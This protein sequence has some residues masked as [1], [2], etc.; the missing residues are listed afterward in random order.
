MKLT[1]THTHLFMEHFDADREQVIRRALEAG[2][3]KMI[4]PN[5]DEKTIDRLHQT[6]KMFPDNLFP[7]MGLHPTSVK[8]DFEQKLQIIE[9]LLKTRKYY[10]IGEIGIDLYWDKTYKEQQIEAFRHQIRLAKELDL[11]VIIHTRDSFEVALQVVKEENDNR[12]RGV[13]HC[14]TG[15]Y[16]QAMQI[17]E[18]GGFYI[19]LGGVLTFKN[20]KLGERI[21][22]VPMDM[23]V[24]ETDSP[25]LTPHPY[26]GKRNE[27]S[28]L[29]YVAKKLAEVKNLSLEQVAQITT[30]NALK[31]FPLS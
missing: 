3:E 14:F 7:A 24:L 23:I 30:E 11:P 6:I 25:F 18:L 9:D 2:V 5:V 10:A 1:D 20:S 13:F 29:V 8:N 16:E 4:L 28:Y 12:L 26:R 15:S 19:G 27:S 22:D 21:K 31:L 17:R